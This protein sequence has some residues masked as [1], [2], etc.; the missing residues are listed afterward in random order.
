MSDAWFNFVSDQCISVNAH[1]SFLSSHHNIVDEVGI[2]GIDADEKC[3]DIN[4]KVQGCEASVDGVVID[5]RYASADISVRKYSS[6][7]RV[8]VPNCAELTL[9]MWLICE[10]RGL[11]DGEDGIVSGDMIKFVVMRG[12]N[13]GHRD[14]HGLIGEK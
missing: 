12:L 9:V 13:Y 7:V 11:D 3:V 6:R 4:I 5:D 1:Y 14:A 2:R 10:N 8:S